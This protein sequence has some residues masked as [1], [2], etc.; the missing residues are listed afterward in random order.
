VLNVLPRHLTLLALG[1]LAA[2]A[3]P[4]AAAD[5]PNIVFIMSDD[6][7]A[8]A[9]SA[10]GSRVNRTPNID[11]LARE[12]ALLEK[13]MATN[14]ICTPSR[15]SILTGQYSHLNGVPV[16]NRFDSWRRTVASLL[17]QSGYYTG[18]IGK[19][20]LGSD[21]VGF[22][23]WEI[24]PGQ[25]VYHDPILYTAA[26]EKTYTGRYATDVITDLSIEFIRNRPRNKPF[27]LMS[28]HKAPHR[29]WEPD[30]AHAAQFANRWVP[31]P[32]TLWDAYD[33]RTD[34]LHENQQR[35][36]AD[37]N[38][39][40]LKLPPPA[41]LTGAALTA[42]LTTKPASVTVRRGGETVTLTGEALVR[43][44]YQR[45][46]QDYLATVQSLDDNIGRLLAFL[47]DSGLSKNTIVIYTSDQG[48]FLGDHGLFDKRFMYEEALRMPFLVRWPAAIK[49][50]TRSSALALNVDFAPTFLD[51]AGVSVPADMQG[52]S[53]LPILR[54]RTPP[55]WRTSMYYRYYHDPGD[56]NTRAHY[57]VRTTTHKLI[58]FW[59]KDQWELFDLVNDPHELH[60]L[61]GLPGHEAVTAAL[62]TELAR[63][64]TSLRDDDQFANEQLPNGVDGPVAR[65]RGK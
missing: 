16:F 38:N 60:N 44:K 9:I 4:A 3:V 14:S 18:M 45:Y 29:P 53:L 23:R 54:G 17:Q 28:H 48:F 41:D 31:E 8:H 10:Y 46:M 50:G 59:K 57:G 51:A 5:R 30:Q 63:L 43:W 33:T 39:R 12:G 15:A 7:A 27:F 56:H 35:V 22:D 34:A 64:K 26:G 47:D 55:D 1:V 40:D 6:H 36:A 37:L 62:K 11:R 49:A 13:V 24:L 61:Y 25:G 2:V 52:R 32:E 58:Y 42:W 65:L 21:P 20:H 19:W